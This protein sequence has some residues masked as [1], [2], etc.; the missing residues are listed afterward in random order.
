[1]QTPS[2]LRRSSRQ[3]SQ[4]PPGFTEKRPGPFLPQRPRQ[5][6]GSF[7]DG[8]QR[9]RAVDSESTH[10]TRSMRHSRA[11]P[12][13]QLPRAHRN[14][15]PPRINRRLHGSGL[16]RLLQRFRIPLAIIMGLGAA[17]ASV[18]AGG[19]GPVETASALRVTTDVAAGERLSG[20]A[21]EEV[22]VDTA[23][24]PGDYSTRMEDVLGQQVAVP[25][26]Q[27]ALIYPDQLVGPGLLAGQPFGTVAVP[28][29]PADPAMVALLTPGQRVDV[30]VSSDSP[31]QGS[32][33]EPVASEVPVLWT[34][35]DDSENWLP[36][37]GE[38]G[39]VV[40]LAVDGATAE[41]IAQATHQGRLHLSLRG[42]G[43]EPGGDDREEAGRAAG[44]DSAG[45]AR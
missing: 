30:L 22:Q 33:S 3:S 4:P 24:V 34:P 18:L 17:A 37:G 7:G 40:I 14:K 38:A 11:A 16:P 19:E 6:R 29:R 13:A 1:M 32:S 31:E 39:S 23:A 44:E 8:R 10:A 20:T 12:S 9:Q 5:D 42:A 21:V 15:K 26:P 43:E 35:Q 25:L 45:G 41:A 36:S 2:A 28:V 27:G